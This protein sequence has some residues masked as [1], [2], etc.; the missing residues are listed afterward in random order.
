[1]IKLFLQKTEQDENDRQVFKNAEEYLANINV[2]NNARGM[3]TAATR[4]VRQQQQQQQ[5]QQQQQQQAQQQQQQQAQQHMH[6]QHLLP[7]LL[8]PLLSTTHRRN[9]VTMLTPT[10]T[11][12]TMST[13]TPVTMSTPTPA[14]AI[15][16][17][18]APYRGLFGS[19]CDSNNRKLANRAARSSI[20]SNVVRE[21][22]MVASDGVP[23]ISV[24]GYASEGNVLQINS[25]SREATLQY[26]PPIRTDQTGQA[27][28]G[29]EEDWFKPSSGDFTSEAKFTRDGN[30]NKDFILKNA[31]TFM[32]WNGLG[33]D[34]FHDLEEDKPGDR[35]RDILFQRWIKQLPTIHPSLHVQYLRWLSIF[36]NEFLVDGFWGQLGGKSLTFFQYVQGGGPEML[37]KDTGYQ[38]GP[39]SSMDSVK[40]R[41]TNGLTIVMA[42]NGRGF[43][44][45]QIGENQGLQIRETLEKATKKEEMDLNLALPII[46]SDAVV[47]MISIGAQQIVP[48]NATYLADARL[49]AGL[50]AAKRPP[51]PVT[52]KVSA[53]QGGTVENPVNIIE[54]AGNLGDSASPTVIPGH[55]NR[56]IYPNRRNN[57]LIGKPPPGK[58]SIV[59]NNF[60]KDGFTTRV[61]KLELTSSG[62]STDPTEIFVGVSKLLHEAGNIVETL[63]IDDII[64]TAKLVETARKSKIVANCEEMVRIDEGLLDGVKSRAE[65]KGDRAM[66]DKARLN[67]E[68]RM[69]ARIQS[70]R[71][72]RGLGSLNVQELSTQ[73]D[74]VPIENGKHKKENE[75]KKR[76]RPHIMATVHNENAPRMR[77][78]IKTKANIKKFGTITKSDDYF[79]V[80]ATLDKGDY[81]ITYN[82]NGRPVTYYPT[83]RIPLHIVQQM[84]VRK[85]GVDYLPLATVLILDEGIRYKMANGIFEELK[86]SINGRLFITAIQGSLT[87]DPSTILGIFAKHKDAIFTPL[88][89]MKQ[90]A[91]AKIQTKKNIGLIPKIYQHHGSPTATH[92]LASIASELFSPGGD[93]LGENMENSGMNQLIAK[94]LR[95][96]TPEHVVIKTLMAIMTLQQEDEEEVQQIG[97]SKTTTPPTT[98]YNCSDIGKD[99]FD[100][101]SRHLL[102]RQ[103]K[104]GY[105]LSAMQESIRRKI[106]PALIAVFSSPRFYTELISV[107]TDEELKELFTRLFHHVINAAGLDVSVH[108][109]YMIFFQ[110][111]T[112]NNID[113][114]ATTAT[115]MKG[116]GCEAGAAALFFVKTQNDTDTGQSPPPH[117]LIFDPRRK[118]ATQQNEFPVLLD[119]TRAVISRDS[120]LGIMLTCE[121][122]PGLEGLLGWALTLSGRVSVRRVRILDYLAFQQFC[123][124][125]ESGAQQGK[126]MKYIEKCWDGKIRRDMTATAATYSPTSFAETFKV[127]KA[128]RTFMK[129][130]AFDP[131]GDDDESDT[132]GKKKK[133]AAAAMANVKGFNVKTIPKFSRK[134]NGLSHNKGSADQGPRTLE[135]V[136]KNIATMCLMV[137]LGI[138]TGKIKKLLQQNGY[139]PAQIDAGAKYCLESSTIEGI[140]TGSDL[141][142]IVI[143][144]IM[145]ML[146]SIGHESSG[147][148]SVEN[149]GFISFDRLA[150]IVGAILQVPS[151]FISA[152]ATNH[153]WGGLNIISSAGTTTARVW[154]DPALTPTLGLFQRS[155]DMYWLTPTT[156][157]IR[158]AR[159]HSIL[160]AVL[161]LLRK[162]LTVSLRANWTAQP[163]EKLLEI[164]KTIHKTSGQT[165]KVN[166]LFSKIAPLMEKI[167][168]AHK[169]LMNTKCNVKSVLE[170]RDINQ[171]MLKSQLERKKCLTYIE[172][173]INEKSKTSVKEFCNPTPNNSSSNTSSSSSSSSNITPTDNSSFAF[174]TT[175]SV[176]NPKN[177]KHSR[178]SETGQRSS[179][180][181][182]KQRQLSL[183]EKK[184]EQMQS[185]DEVSKQ[186]AI[187]VAKLHNQDIDRI[188]VNGQNVIQDLRGTI[189]A[190]MGTRAIATVRMSI[191]GITRPVGVPGMLAIKKKKMTNQQAGVD[192]GPAMTLLSQQ[193]RMITRAIGRGNQFLEMIE[194]DRGNPYFGR[195]NN[196]HD[197]TTV[198]NIETT[199]R[200]LIAELETSKQNI[201][202]RGG[203]SRKRRHRKRHQTRRKKKRI[204]KKTIRK[205]RKRGRK[206]RRK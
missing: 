4:W 194:A 178:D 107:T 22:L 164:L 34:I 159:L 155:L 13:P 172:N 122:H 10:S 150:T 108:Q 9:T 94:R 80:Q 25:D 55:E 67:N 61:N 204:Q 16:P 191:D 37:E 33:N 64:S 69:H 184:E 119:I 173:R 30:G 127:V 136:Y 11:P 100:K 44:S 74:A 26:R 14:T 133:A 134:D 88:T 98:Q 199:I 205:R 95:S 195:F 129:D 200:D 201:G 157:K 156:P 84:I 146:F 28:A 135:A 175:M 190:T 185:A 93:F 57:M 62:G 21:R 2:S 3:A 171:D 76:M 6:S 79:L 40:N 12:V 125:V 111:W 70:V 167:S 24:S 176:L 174:S 29:P 181:D 42:R 142:Q 203:G 85:Q 92:H 15:V 46:D 65:M 31:Q 188:I 59:Q 38:P 138:E 63:T 124:S 45:V 75:M 39:T 126:R 117:H 110:E 143:E 68:A 48:V 8:P 130:F 182:V 47:Q 186:H 87:Q 120:N 158:C 144:K 1:M 121:T 132:S 73:G 51:H 96:N 180:R 137:K 102:N 50:D 147:T 160:V 154:R 169:L 32:Q 196:M 168:D 123:S 140:K 5:A 109:P 71:D 198:K 179:G 163:V 115:A 118:T 7:P 177:K 141:L 202:S 162:E 116:S 128:R 148:V 149:F 104:L 78:M 89:H 41:L 166:E 54:T 36:F 152:K 43:V 187:A 106:Q 161:D 206:T 101:I 66:S 151:M 60:M 165:Q 145:G 189:A 113:F 27:A 77:R 193:H 99:V 114:L 83:G 17:G 97:E 183:K 103:D 81:S 153:A 90:H 56:N 23:S 35:C 53:V 72:T 58:K 52:K 49:S 197:A 131:G 139:G 170:T 105:T 86:N 192:T 82:R 19:I 112:Q 18:F 20:L 91:Y